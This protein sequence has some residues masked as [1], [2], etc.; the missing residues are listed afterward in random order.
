MQK[1]PTHPH[2]VDCICTSIALLYPF[3]FS[4]LQA[5]SNTQRYTQEHILRWGHEVQ[6]FSTDCVFKTSGRRGKE[7]CST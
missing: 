6:K 3:T 1:V 5:Y 4:L 7:N 2:L